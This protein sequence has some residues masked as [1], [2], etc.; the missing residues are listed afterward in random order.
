MTDADP[1]PTARPTPAPTLGRSGAGIFFD[2]LTDLGV[3]VIF[4]HTGGAVIP[5]HVEL[6]KRMRRTGVSEGTE[7]R[8]LILSFSVQFRGRRITRAVPA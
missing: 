4:G 3:E 5:L 2:V 7:A 6:N 8:R 1:S